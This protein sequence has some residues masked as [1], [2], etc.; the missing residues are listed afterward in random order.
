MWKTLS[1]AVRSR[2]MIVLNSASSGIASLLLPGG[3]TAHLRFAIPIYPDDTTLCTMN[4]H[5][6]LANVVKESSLIIWDEAPMMSKYCFESLDRSLANV[7]GNNENKPFG[8]K[9]I[10]FGGDFR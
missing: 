10:V 9:V 1:A 4:P 8:G 5:S 6:D 2:G 3:R 7:I